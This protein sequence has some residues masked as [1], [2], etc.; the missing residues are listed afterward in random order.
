MATN[1]WRYLS[2]SDMVW[3]L[4]SDEGPYLA[5]ADLAPYPLAFLTTGMISS[6]MNEIQA[7]ARMRGIG[8]NKITLAQDMHF[9]K[10]GASGGTGNA[11]EAEPVETHVYLKSS[12]DD[13]FARTILDM[14]EKTCFLHAFCRTD[15]KTRYRF[16][17]I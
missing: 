2:V 4:C 11:G 15:L 10:G 17:R 9:S 5:G 16:T 8:L 12:E 1:F 13:D 7:L 6:Y 14:A 3:R